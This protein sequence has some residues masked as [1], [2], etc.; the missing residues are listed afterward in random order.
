MLNMVRINGGTDPDDDE[1]ATALVHEVHLTNTGAHAYQQGE[2][3]TLI[4]VTAEGVPVL[5]GHDPNP[6]RAIYRHPH[7][8]YTPWGVDDPDYAPRGVQP[9]PAPPGA[10]TTNVRCGCDTVDSWHMPNMPIPP[11][12]CHLP[13]SI[14]QIF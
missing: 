14:T 10:L 6:P 8:N 2:A 5:A 3:L 1:P 7:S 4:G 9:P 11:C 12:A 13:K